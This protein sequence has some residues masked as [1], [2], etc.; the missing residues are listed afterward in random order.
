MYIRIYTH[1]LCCKGVQSLKFIAMVNLLQPAEHK[2]VEPPS[3]IVSSGVGCC[4]IGLE[5]SLCT[6]DQLF[7]DLMPS[8]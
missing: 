2:A 1:Q 4:S 3:K 6:T 5:C 8:C 7:S